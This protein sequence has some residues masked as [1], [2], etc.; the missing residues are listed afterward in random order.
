MNTLKKQAR[1]T[2][3]LYL[4]IIIG[5]LFTEVFV[6]SK[7]IDWNSPV[8]TAQNIIEFE[9][10][11]RLGFSVDLIVFLCDIGVAI[12]LYKIL[13]P[14]SHTLAAITASLRLTMVAISAVNLLNLYKP[15]AYLKGADYLSIFNIEQLQA[16]STISLKTHNY[17]YHIALVFFGLHCFFLGYLLIKSIN[18]PKVLGVLLMLASF[19]YLINS[20]SNF[21]P[22]YV[23]IS[24]IYLLLPAFVAE[25]SFCLWLLIKGIKTVK[26]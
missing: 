14:I 23:S 24:Y 7:I 12:L 10:L 13:K 3:F 15:L 9:T 26:Q 21:M 6:R 25:V 2:G 16:L 17:G 4:I 22:N 8:I 1:I 20:F 11:Y 18:F 19:G 5:G